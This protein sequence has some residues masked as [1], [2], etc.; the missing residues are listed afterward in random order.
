MDTVQK[1]IDT[2]RVLVQDTKQEK[3]PDNFLLEMINEEYRTEVTLLKLLH[4]KNTITGDG[5]GRYSLDSN[6]TYEPADI[7]RIHIDSEEIPRQRLVA[8]DVLVGTGAAARVVAEGSNIYVW[9][10]VALS[11][12]LTEQTLTT[13][14]GELTAAKLDSGQS[15][16]PT[17]SGD[18][19]IDI[20]S[21]YQDR[22]CY[23]STD[24][25]IS[26]GNVTFGATLSAAGASGVPYF[27]IIVR[28]L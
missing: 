5:T 11:D 17:F 25:S 3:Y 6:L 10:K 8:S 7:K 1:V 4:K 28:Q 27:D 23:I 15:A 12:V 2:I 18:I 9:R 22:T 19:S 26:S 24:P 21:G 20:S 14:S 16:L 13:G